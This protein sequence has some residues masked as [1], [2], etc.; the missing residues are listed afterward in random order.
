MSWSGDSVRMGSHQ[1]PPVAIE[2]RSLS[3][4]S[5]ANVRSGV[6]RVKG[7]AGDVLKEKFASIA[8]VSKVLFTP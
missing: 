6:H 5:R 1:A 8:R 7:E 3:S 2:D 4:S